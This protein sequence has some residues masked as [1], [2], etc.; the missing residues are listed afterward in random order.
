MNLLFS[1]IPFIV[2]INSIIGKEHDRHRHKRE[3]L[4]YGDS[5]VQ[6][7][8][9]SNYLPYIKDRL[10]KSNPDFQVTISVVADKGNDVHDLFSGKKE[11]I[12]NRRWEKNTKLHINKQK[13]NLPDVI[14]V[15]WDSDSETE[16]IDWSD[17]K[18]EKFRDEYKTRL[19]NLISY[20][21]INIRHVALAGPGLDGEDK[22]DSNGRQFIIESYRTINKVIC[23]NYNI[24]YIDIRLELLNNLPYNNNR[25]KGYLTTDGKHLNKNGIKVVA[26]KFIKVLDNW[27]QLWKK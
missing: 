20:L 18:R 16:D 7:L 5:H 3:I 22:E 6:S 24:K 4:F 13:A 15:Y 27:K 25:E 9:Y 2:L 1:V 10:E 19:S 8:N 12:L 14:I 21:K 26:N 23:S 11:A 17:N